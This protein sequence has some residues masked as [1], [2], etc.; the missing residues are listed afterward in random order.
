MV[1]EIPPLF[2]DLVLTQ[3]TAGATAGSMSWRD[4]GGGG[5]RAAA[6]GA[7]GESGVRQKKNQERE[8]PGAGPTSRFNGSVQD[9][10][11]MGE[12]P[13]PLDKPGITIFVNGSAH[14]FTLN[15]FFNPY[16]N[17]SK[18]PFLGFFSIFATQI[19]LHYYFILFTIFIYNY[20]YNNYYY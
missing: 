14:K 19:H 7:S 11:I 4:G 20:K 5:W 1:W 15:A 13:R 17:W 12:F 10:K 8:A 6:T 18:V 2:W 9:P 3:E 16:I